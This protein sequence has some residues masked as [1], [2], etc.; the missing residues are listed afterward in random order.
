MTPT[1][2]FASAPRLP[3]QLFAVRLNCVLLTESVGVTAAT[4]AELLMVIVCGWLDTP[5]LCGAKVK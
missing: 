2:Q 5:G 1:V 3:V 4:P